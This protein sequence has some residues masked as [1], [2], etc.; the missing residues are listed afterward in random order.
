MNIMKK[1]LFALLPILLSLSL[2]A[3]EDPGKALKKASRALGSY[4]LDQTANEAK[5]DEAVEYIEIAAASETT[6]G[7][8]KLW[9][10]RGEIYNALAQ[11]DVGNMVADQEYLPKRPEA[12]V[13]AAESFLKALDLA[14]KKYEKKDGYTGIFESGR[15]LNVIGNYKIQTAEYADAYRYFDQILTIHELLTAN[16]EES[17]ILA[18]DYTNQRFLTAFCAKIAGEKDRSKELFNGLYTEEANDPS[19]YAQYFQLLDEDDDPK[20]LEVLEK[21]RSMYPD[22]P[23]IL[24][25]EINYYIA[26]ERFDIL[27]E[28]LKKAIDKEPD[29]AS[30][31]SAL[32]NV[33]MNLYNE[34]FSKTPE[35]FVKNGDSENGKRYYD[36]AINY[37]NQALELDAKS[38]DAIYS[39]GSMYFNRAVENYKVMANLTMSKA[40]QA[41]YEKLEGEA[42]DFMS[43]ALPY[44]KNAEA[45]NP[46]D[47][48]TLIA[49]S[50]IFA[51][52]QDFEN[53]KGIKARLEEVKAGT[54]FD[55]SYFN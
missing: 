6:H 11:K 36:G 24:F 55:S 28:K 5:L 26:Q 2:T 49:L 21:G 52:T 4:N 8:I 16:G 31:R 27:E 7:N 9:Q 37:F 45:I 29:N 1:L 53:S 23:E 10:T 51:R 50:E 38:W 18:S 40:D 22:N 19:I 54:Q 42:K 46:N 15:H 13:K 17:P 12:G 3:Q 41:L 34:E 14:E 33:Y 25:A 30:V 20:A 47:Q 39:I 44:F 43:Q 35:E 48:N 32:G